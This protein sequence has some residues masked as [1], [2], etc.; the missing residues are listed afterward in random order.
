[1]A[2]NHGGGPG[3]FFGYQT[4]YAARS[5]LI[6]VWHQTGEDREPGAVDPLHYG[7]ANPSGDM[8]WSKNPSQDDQPSN[9]TQENIDTVQERIQALKADQ[10]VTAALGWRKLGGIF[11]SMITAIGAKTE[12]MAEGTLDGGGWSSPAADVFYAK[13]PG[14]TM[15][16]LT[17]WREAASANEQA[18]NDLSS[19]ILVHQGSMQTLYHQYLLDRGRLDAAWNQFWSNAGPDGKNPAPTLGDGLKHTDLD[20]AA[21]GYIDLVKRH[22]AGALKPSNSGLPYEWSIWENYKYQQHGTGDN[23]NQKAA[24]LQYKLGQAFN[25]GINTLY[26]QG[27]ATRFEGPLD[28]VSVD[29]KVVQNLIQ[30]WMMQNMPGVPGMGG[31]PSF[32]TPSFAMPMVIMPNITNLPSL[33]INTL[34]P[35]SLSGVD[36]STL[37]SLTDVPSAMS[38]DPN[39]VNGLVAP[40]VPDT[41]GL[42]SDLTGPAGLTGLVGLTGLA[43]MVNPS[44]LNG[45]STGLLKGPLSVPNGPGAAGGFPPSP[46][47]ANNL[48]KDT[49]RNLQRGVL[50]SRRSTFGEEAPPDDEHAN[51][52]GMPPS[53]S[54]GGAAQRRD[55]RQQQVPG[56]PLARET[57]GGEGGMSTPTSPPVLGRDKDQKGRSAGRPGRRPEAPSGRGFAPGGTTPPVLGRAQAGDTVSRGKSGAQSK[58]ERQRDSRHPGATQPGDSDWVTRANSDTPP[59]T[60]PVLDGSGRMSDAERAGSAW[61]DRFTAAPTQAGATAPVLGRSHPHAGAGAAAFSGRPVEPELG[62]R[63]HTAANA[64]AAAAAGHEEHSPVISDETAF[65]V[66]TPGGAVFG[67]DAGR[68]SAPEAEPKPTLGAGQ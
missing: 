44:S 52:S 45:M 12:A 31:V 58:P 11:D 6:R 8:Q 54:P 66:E 55:G 43:G 17:D 62:A 29:P 51:S 33:P 39:L 68:P 41:S 30:Q 56:S 40:T 2:D 60:A 67:G 37:P 16:S 59:A 27:R 19:V 42:S 23:W 26:S 5:Q 35:N 7:D 13:G 48:V 47:S 1:M 9:A 21:D 57:F 10:V 28:A 34:D 32:S 25:S 50:G 20:F 24:A 18:L 38:L 53:S 14:A 15:K 4:D 64:A 63:H 3:K 36:P 49:R 22:R 65:S 46:F 61:S